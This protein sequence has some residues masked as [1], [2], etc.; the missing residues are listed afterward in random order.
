MD[1]KKQV[2]YFKSLPYETKRTKVLEMLKQLQWT[3]EIFAMF[4]K[5]VNSLAKV[6]ESVLLYLYQSIME[7][8][9]DIEAGRKDVV[10][11]K[12]KKMAEVLMMIKK[13]EEMEREREGNPEELLKKI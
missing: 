5:T 11:D 8:A 7:I 9:T 4:Y 6:S 3:H 13:Q 12:I 1:I 10:Q 2:E